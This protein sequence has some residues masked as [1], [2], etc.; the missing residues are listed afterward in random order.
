MEKTTLRKLPDE[1]KKGGDDCSKL[2]KAAGECVGGKRGG[3]DADDKQ[4]DKDKK[5]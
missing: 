1:D 2:A 4:K 3:K 5:D